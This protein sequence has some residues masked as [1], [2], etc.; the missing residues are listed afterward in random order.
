[1]GKSWGFV[2]CTIPRIARMGCSPC[3]QDE[4][5][6]VPIRW[7]LG[8]SRMLIYLCSLYIQVYSAMCPILSNYHR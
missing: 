4:Q 1:M 3:A 5:M 7:N 8:N 6:P 2:L